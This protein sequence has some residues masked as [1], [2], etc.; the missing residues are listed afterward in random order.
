MT[1][2]GFRFLPIEKEVI[3]ATFNGFGLG[4][5]LHLQSCHLG[6]N[7]TILATNNFVERTPFPFDV[8]NMKPLSRKL[9][10]LTLKDAL[11]FAIN[12]DLLF[13]ILHFTFQTLHV[14]DEIN[15]IGGRRGLN[16]LLLQVG[17]GLGHRRVEGGH[18][19]AEH[20]SKLGQ[21]IL[22]PR[23]VFQG[24]FRL[25]LAIIDD[26]GAKLFFGVTGVKG[27]PGLLDVRQELHPLANVFTK[28]V[29]QA[30]GLEIPQG[31]V[32]KP[33]INVTIGKITKIL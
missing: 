4:D 27:G 18:L 7:G 22:V 21:S 6:L 31:L 15:G 12:I 11:A 28:L 30:V 24:H 19:G 32:S 17:P 26:H 33:L 23:I 8:I 10:P 9:K 2:N 1:I 5:D 20:V 25:D 16:G 3:G 13:P 29:V 14:G